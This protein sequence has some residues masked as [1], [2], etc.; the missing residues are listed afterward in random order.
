VKYAGSSRLVIMH[1]DRW[2]DGHSTG[3]LEVSFLPQRAGFGAQAVV[4]KETSWSVFMLTSFSVTL[5]I[6]TLMGYVERLKAKFK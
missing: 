5:F 6:A 2:S 4:K 3:W 1:S